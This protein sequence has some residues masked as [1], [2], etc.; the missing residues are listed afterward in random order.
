M[1]RNIRLTEDLSTETWQARKDWHDIYRVVN[2]KNMYLRIHYPGRLL[3]RI[4]GEIK[5]FQERQKLKEYVTT[6]PA[7]QVILR[8]TL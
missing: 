2:E 1:G 6:N 8:G 5:S 4:K 3:F 7:L